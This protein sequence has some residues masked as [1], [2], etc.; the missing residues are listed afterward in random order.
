MLIIRL[1]PLGTKGRKKLIISSWGFLRGLILCFES[2]TYKLLTLSQSA[3]ARPVCFLHFRIV[4][5]CVQLTFCTFANCESATSVH[6]VLSHAAKA[7]PVGGLYFRRVRKH[8]L[9]TVRTFA[10]FKGY[11]SLI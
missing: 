10:R 3:K 6:F 2:A 9:L 11:K 7:H 5:K 8:I 1:F 4:R